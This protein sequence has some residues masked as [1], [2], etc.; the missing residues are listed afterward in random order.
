MLVPLAE[1][2]WEAQRSGQAPDEQ[3]YLQ[4]LQSL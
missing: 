4:R 1:A 2:L 3:T